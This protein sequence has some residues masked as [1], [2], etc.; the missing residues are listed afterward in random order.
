M[1][2][3]KITKK[4]TGGC[5]YG[6]YDSTFCEFMRPTQIID[7]EIPL[8]TFLHYLDPDADKKIDV[9][10][11]K[12]PGLFYNYDDRLYGDKWDEGRK[13]AAKSAKLNS[14]RYFE[15]T[16]NHFHGVDS[17]DIGHI[18][19]GCNRSNGFSYLIFGYTYNQPEGA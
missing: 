2:N 15:I 14:A 17:V 4:N 5:G 9:F 6:E 16:L 8:R 19:L 3:N 13:I 1:S 11:C 7:K 10:G 18:V 12:K